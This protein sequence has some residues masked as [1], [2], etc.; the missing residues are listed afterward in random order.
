MNLPKEIMGLLRKKAELPHDYVNPNFL[1]LVVE[2]LEE[3]Y[4]IEDDI[5]DDWISNMWSA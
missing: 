2:L 4:D 3:Y 1:Q 5:V